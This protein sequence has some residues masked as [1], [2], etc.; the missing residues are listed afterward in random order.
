LFFL[1][2][3]GDD[4]AD[5]FYCCRLVPRKDASPAFGVGRG[6]PAKHLFDYKPTVADEFF[7]F[8]SPP[9]ENWGSLK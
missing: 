5:L 7:I 4:P 3:P 6:S 8:S 2:T 9:R 1:S